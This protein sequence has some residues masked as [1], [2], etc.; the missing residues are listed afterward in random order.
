MVEVDVDVDDEDDD[1]DPTE[2]DEL[3]R[4]RLFRGMNIRDTSS[5]L[6]LSRFPCP[7]VVECHAARGTGWK[8]GGGATA[9]MGEREA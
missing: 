2:D 3:V 8:L 6:M 9:V 7:L 4:W 5:V 1:E